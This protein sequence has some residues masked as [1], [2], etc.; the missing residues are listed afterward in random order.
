MLKSIPVKTIG[1]LVRTGKKRIELGSFARLTFF[2]SCE[3]FDPQNVILSNSSLQVLVAMT[4]H[5][6]FYNGHHHSPVS[7]EFVTPIPV[8]EFVSLPTIQLFPS[9]FKNVK[10]YTKNNQISGIWAC[11]LTE[12]TIEAY[13]ILNQEGKIDKCLITLLRTNKT[14]IPLINEERD[15]V[16]AY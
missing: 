15:R 12:E 9:V 6:D 5:N 14:P 8:V 10:I 11:Q 1:E 7:I 16:S 4:Y 2:D 13:K 3:K